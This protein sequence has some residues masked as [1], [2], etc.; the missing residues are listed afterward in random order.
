MLIYFFYPIV[1]LKTSHNLFLFFLVHLLFL[2]FEFIYSVI[3][4]MNQCLMKAIA[5]LSLIYISL[6]PISLKMRSM[7]SQ[8]RLANMPAIKSL[9]LLIEFWI[10]TFSFVRHCISYILLRFILCC[11]LIFNVMRYI[12]TLWPAQPEYCN[13]CRV[14]TL[15]QSSQMPPLRNMCSVEGILLRNDKFYKCYCI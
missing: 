10:E 15:V 14:C 7:L 3:S 9:P 12:M 4:F 13:S 6:R 8:Q 1:L 11:V 5:N 2:P